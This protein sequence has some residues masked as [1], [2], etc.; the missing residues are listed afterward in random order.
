MCGDKFACLAVR[1]GLPVLLADR[2]GRGCCAPCN[3]QFSMA[4]DALVMPALCSSRL[5]MISAEQAPLVL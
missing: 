3:G 1:L 5:H 4:G 2:H